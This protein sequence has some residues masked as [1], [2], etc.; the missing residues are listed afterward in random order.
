MVTGDSKF[1]TPCGRSSIGYPV[2]VEQRDVETS[3]DDYNQFTQFVSRNV[4][5]ANP[6]AFRQSSFPFLKN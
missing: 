4:I 3:C 1:E 2:E 6:D 5:S